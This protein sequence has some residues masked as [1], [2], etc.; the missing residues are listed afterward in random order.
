MVS[1]TTVA[2]SSQMV[3]YH[4]IFFYFVFEFFEL[5]NSLLKCVGMVKNQKLPENILTPTTK[6]KHHDVPISPDEVCPYCSCFY[7]FSVFFS[8]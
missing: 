6:A 8:L 1:E 5:S 7:D 2:I 4:Y 3:C